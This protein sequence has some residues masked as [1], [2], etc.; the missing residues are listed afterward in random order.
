[1]AVPLSPRAARLIARLVPV[2]LQA[3]VF[4]LCAEAP[5]LTGPASTAALDRVHFAVIR[6]AAEGERSFAAAAQLYRIDTRDLLV[7][8]GFADDARAHEAWFARVCGGDEGATG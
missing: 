6:L 8:A 4:A 7:N 2:A 5:A 1:M 3:R